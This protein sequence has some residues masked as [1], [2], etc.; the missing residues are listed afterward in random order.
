IALLVP[1]V[2]KVREAASR[3]QCT[4]NLKQIT[5]AFHSYHDTNKKIPSLSTAYNG[6]PVSLHFVLLPYIEQNALYND[7]LST[8][9]CQ[10]NAGAPTA[11]QTTV[12]STF[13]CPSD[14]LSH[15]FGLTLP[16]ANSSYN[17][18]AATNY[19]GNHFVFGYYTGTLSAPSWTPPG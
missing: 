17:N 5:L 8:G 16:L 10:T 7:G 14:G 12:V 15:P 6:L 11:M 9:G 13:V 3:T 19:P 2:Q 4:N 18:W 1:A